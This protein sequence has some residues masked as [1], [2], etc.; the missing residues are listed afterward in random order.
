MIFKI[1]T[2]PL[3]STENEQS[4]S[5]FFKISFRRWFSISTEDFEQSETQSN[6]VFTFVRHPECVFVVQRGRRGTPQDS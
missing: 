4:V 2:T 3:F 6:V 5:Y 1:K